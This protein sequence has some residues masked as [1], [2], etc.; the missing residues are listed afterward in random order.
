MKKI[1]I[2][3]TLAGLLV[4][5]AK[6]QV[7]PTSSITTSQLYTTQSNSL[8]GINGV[9]AS[10]TFDASGDQTLYGRN[11]YFL[12]DM[13]SDYAGAGASAINPF[14]QAISKAAWDPNTDRL[15]VAWKQIYIGINL[16]NLAVDNLPTSQVTDPLKTRLINEAK[17]IRAL[18]Y[19]DAVRLWGAVPLVLHQ[20]TSLDPS[21]LNIGRTSV[22]S[23]YAQIISDLTAAQGLPAT[24]SSSDIGRA[25]SG[26]ATSLLAK[27]YLT[28]RD[29]A[30]AATQARSVYTSG[31]YQLF[32]NF[33]DAFN[34]ATKN[35]KEHIFS[36]QFTANQGLNGT[37]N[38]NT[39]TQTSFS[40]F[41]AIQP[42]DIIS[43]TTL[44]YNI[45]Q[46]G[47]T[48][49]AGS[50]AKQLLN[51]ATN[52]LY[53]FPLPLFRKFLDT[54]NYSGLT[55]T[56]INN[57]IIRYADVLLILAE[58]DNEQ[59][60][61]PNAEAFEA[62]NQVRRRAFGYPITTAGSPV[63]LTLATTPDQS[64]F[65]EAVF[66]ERLLEF[67]QEGQ[68]WFDLVRRG[69]NTGTGNPYFVDALKK[70]ASKQAVSAKDTLYP[71]PQPERNINPS[72]LYQNPG[73]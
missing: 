64:T 65:R 56:P 47:D 41:I 46:P 62:I 17:F 27:V 20:P 10:L 11:L 34:K 57:P 16:A 63:D 44:F 61:G 66:Q 68:R 43:D 52:T 15:E 45:Y 23:V 69:I 54:T 9:Y 26:A 38:G 13:G 24:Y 1:I 67:V 39:L 18:L 19:F 73:Y 51:P 59:N 4:S 40:G 49:Q 42:A 22:D 14:V 25:T 53:T 21:A 2:S 48:R 29:W 71:I 5:C 55:N 8:A 70:V 3:I 32:T 72:G 6:L 35:G 37:T 12:T 28:R 30:D 60:G 58:A 7:T 36:A 31:T 33:S 50:Y